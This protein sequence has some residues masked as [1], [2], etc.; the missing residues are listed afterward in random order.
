MFFSSIVLAAPSNDN[1][2]SAIEITNFPYT[3]QQ[4]S[5][6]AGNEPTELLS[7]CFNDFTTKLLKTQENFLESNTFNDLQ[8]YA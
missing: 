7:K 1:L 4:S 2:A 3:N 8:T 6:Q 5:Q